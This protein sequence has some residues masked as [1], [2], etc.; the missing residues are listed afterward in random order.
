MEAN[1]R[2]KVTMPHLVDEGVLN[3]PGGRPS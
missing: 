1:D 2:L 3:G